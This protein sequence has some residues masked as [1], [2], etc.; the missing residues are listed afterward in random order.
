MESQPENPKI[1]NN[2]DSFFLLFFFVD[3]LRQS[4]ILQS[5]S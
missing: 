3:A 2:P 4:T 5:K 1:R